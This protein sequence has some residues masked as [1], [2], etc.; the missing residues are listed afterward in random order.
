MKETKQLNPPQNPKQLPTYKHKVGGKQN[1]KHHQITSVWLSTVCNK[2]VDD[3]S[4]KS[5][6]Q[7]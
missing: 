7:K 6:E 3:Y 1:K 5:T 2:G 4:H